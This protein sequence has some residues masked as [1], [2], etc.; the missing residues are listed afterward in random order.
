MA[1][2]RHLWSKIEKSLNIYGVFFFVLFLRQDHKALDSLELC[3]RRSG[4]KGI[5]TMP[6]SSCFLKLVLM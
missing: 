5:Y 3:L 1:F 4:V 2:L 6:G